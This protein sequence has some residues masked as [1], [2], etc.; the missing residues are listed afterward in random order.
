LNDQGLKIHR[1]LIS[2]LAL[3]ERDRTRAKFDISQ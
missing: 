3:I 1:L 2:R